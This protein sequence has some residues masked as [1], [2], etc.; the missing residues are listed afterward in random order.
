[1]SVKEKWLIGFLFLLQALFL[2]STFRTWLPVC[3]ATLISGAIV[4]VWHGR[5]ARESRSPMRRWL[6][7]TMILVMLAAIVSVTTVWRLSSQ[8]GESINPIYVGIDIVTHVALFSSLFVWT[9][10]SDRGHVSMLPLGLLVV[11]LCVAAG[12]ASQSFAAQST[13]ALAACLGFALAS[14]IILAAVRDTGDVRTV[15]HPAADGNS[16][17]MGL[18]F[19]MLTLSILLM[20]T[21]VIANA[22][23]LVL[24]SIQDKVQKQLQASFDAAG[25]DL[26]IGGTRYVKGSR[27]GS[28]RRHMLGDPQEIALRIAGDLSPGY[29]RG[30]AFDL[31]RTRR[32]TSA[33]N[34][35]V[36]PYSQIPS[37]KDRSV[38]PSGT[39][40]VE[41][42]ISLRTPLLR[43]ELVPS[44]NEKTVN[45]EIYNDPLKGPYV[46]LPLT[47]RWVEASSRNLVV[48]SHGIVRLGVD[49]TKPYVA[50]VGRS[51]R[52]E[53]L[54]PKRREMLLAVPFFVSPETMRIADQVCAA[55][56]TAPA[57]AAAVSQFFQREFSY[58]L[59]ATQTPEDTDPISH[60]LRTQHAAHCEFFASATVLVL[61]SA[62]VPARYVTGYV[63]D[64]FSDEE[65]MWVARNGDA[66]AWAEAY[67]DSTGLWIPVEST[68]G[69]TYQTVDP[70]D[71][72]QM[73]EGFFDALGM[74]DGADGNSLLGRTLGWLL[75]IRATDPLMIVFR[76]AQLPL[77]CVL[78]FLLWSRYLRPARSDVDSI[79]L[80]SR[81]MLGKVDRRLRKHSLVRMP[82]ETLYQFADRIDGH[83]SEPAQDGIRELLSAVSVWYRDYAN[84][85]YQG[86]L[87][88]PYL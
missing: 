45:L 43:F 14:Q 54:D 68:P 39:G 15:R 34:M 20:A 72:T 32:W 80:R 64:E 10:Q 55:Q 31:Y 77:F 67:D 29:L 61:R 38:P 70:T 44:G 24:P 13:V 40:T 60:F 78:A 73:S 83:R 26:Y 58:S 23:N 57:K 1:M 63:A 22:T 79:D 21:S 2:A 18:L 84:A 28:I 11:L 35:R 33:Q 75:S 69:R 48:T 42:K 66:H 19:S 52:R 50:G 4:F 76:I 56:P 3:T 47:T 49:V 25:E 86:E 65:S 37:S 5:A 8:I 59:T 41:L 53:R 6:S 17:R 36:G 88:T 30:H 46:F 85:R 74:E 27:I 87:P 51:V 62:G 81:K 9:I 71:E 16:G 82:S 7:W 12:G